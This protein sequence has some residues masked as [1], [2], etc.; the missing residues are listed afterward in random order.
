MQS[1]ATNIELVV[2]R[3]RGNSLEDVVRKPETKK[4][5]DDYTK[6]P[7][8]TQTTNRLLLGCPTELTSAAITD[9]LG[10]AKT[11]I[12]SMGKPP[13]PTPEEKKE[14]EAPKTGMRKFSSHGDGYLKNKNDSANIRALRSNRP[15]SLTL[16]IFTVTFHKGAGQKSLG[17]SIVG[18]YDSPKGNMGIFVK[19]IFKTGQAAENGTLRE[20]KI[21]L[22]LF[23][24]HLGISYL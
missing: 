17:F 1:N 23:K 6:V 7:P 12:Q 24:L 21:N 5:T 19:T 15:K 16:S 8:L 10:Q 11:K 4:A 3:C 20:G 9:R 18:G 2:A 14:P 13:I 22:H